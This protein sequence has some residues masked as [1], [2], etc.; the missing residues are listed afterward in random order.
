MI[1]PS[2]GTATLAER[3]RDG[4]NV[5][6]CQTCRGVWLDRGELEKLT[7]LARADCEAN[8][9][10]DAPGPLRDSD[11]SPQRGIRIRS[12]DDG[13]HIAAPRRKRRWYESFGDI[14]D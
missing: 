1:C 3:E 11:D 2:C 5:D 9:G 7:S 6:V 13:A 14:F 4:V 12:D 8:A 10:A